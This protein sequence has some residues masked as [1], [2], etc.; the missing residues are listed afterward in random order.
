[1]IHGMMVNNFTGGVFK[2]KDGVDTNT[3]ADA[4]RS[5]FQSNQ[6]LCGQPESLLV[7]VIGDRYVLAAFGLSDVLTAVQSNLTAAYPN[8][9]IKYQEAIE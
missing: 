7:A 9:Q 4:M 1:M 8:T 2:L 6:W 5:A 3:F